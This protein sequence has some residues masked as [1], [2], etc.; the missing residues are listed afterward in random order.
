MNL[1]SKIFTPDKLSKSDKYSMFDLMNIYY[2]NINRK[3]FEADLSEKNW[4]VVLYDGDNLIKGFSTIM[5]IDMVVQGKKIKIVFSGDTI[6]DRDYWGNSELAVAWGKF[7][8]SIPEKFPD[9]PIYWLLISKGYKTYMFLPIYFNEFYPRYNSDTP[10][11]E[12]E[13]MKSFAKF[14]YPERYDENTGLIYANG[15]NDMLKMG[16]ADVTKENLQDPNVEYFVQKNNGYLNG[17]ELVCISKVSM[18]NLQEF[19][20]PYVISN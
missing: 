12:Q 7:V 10:D 16:I 13:I 5:L 6:L 17:D 8:F 14:K 11:F 18:N 9:T 2:D 4:I 19:I 15:I 3:Q 20:R 1:H